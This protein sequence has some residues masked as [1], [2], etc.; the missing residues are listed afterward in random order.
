[1]SLTEN[2]SPLKVLVVDDTRTNILILRTALETEGY[3]VVTASNGAEAIARFQSETPDVILMDVVMPGIDGFEATR[4]IR[5][6]SDKRWVPIIFLSAL[7]GSHEVVAG[8]EAGG[9]DFLTKPVD[10][11]LLFAKLR[12]MQRIAKMQRTLEVYHTQSEQEQK[13]AQRLM[14]RMLRAHSTED[15]RIHVSLWPATRFSGDMALVQH[16]CAGD[17]YVLLADNMGHGLTAA[18]PA[19]PLS[20]V[21]SAMSHKGYTLPAMAQRMN[22]EIRKLLPIGHFVVAALVRINWSNQLL[23][24]WNGGIPGVLA[25]DQSGQI[26]HR[27]LSKSF[28]LGVVDTHEFTHGT[29]IWHWDEPHTIMLFTDGLS[30]AQNQAGE[31]LS[32]DEIIAA[33]AQDE[34][35]KTLQQTLTKLLNGTPAHDDISVVTMKLD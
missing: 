30:E 15:A 14:G 3:T 26:A 27:F 13:L 2:T 28:A 25:V 6:L 12:A 1:M 18:L 31:C 7:T 4:Q 35:H 8:L 33:L 32:E 11:S 17:T 21:F 34:E 24:V 20:Q 9:D 22:T 23:E 5:Q 19:L 16:S 29:E 10:V